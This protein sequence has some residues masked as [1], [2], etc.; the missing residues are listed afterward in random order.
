MAGG[1]VVWVDIEEAGGAASP[2]AQESVGAAG[3]HGAGPGPT[4]GQVVAGHQRMQQV[5]RTAE[6]SSVEGK[7][8]EEVT[9]PEHFHGLGAVSQRRSFPKPEPC[10]KTQGPIHEP[11]SGPAES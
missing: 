7:C 2:Y 8:Q 10:E 4:G 6:P 9:G 11:V 5:Q 3:W 1:W